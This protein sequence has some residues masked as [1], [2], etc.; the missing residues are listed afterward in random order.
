MSTTSVSRLVTL[1]EQHLGV[2]LLR[3]TTRH[4]HVTDD[5]QRYYGKCVQILKLSEEAEH[6][7]SQGE[8]VKGILRLSFPHDF[9]PEFILPHIISFRENNPGV[10][11]DLIVTDATINLAREGVDIAIRI[12]DNIHQ[13]LIARRLTETPIICC[14]APEYL[15]LAGHPTHPLDLQDHNCLTYALAGFGAL[16]P[17]GKDGQEYASQVSGDFRGDSGRVLREI[18]LKGLGIVLLPEFLVHRDI[19]EGRLVPVLGD[20][21]HNAFGIYAVYETTSRESQKIKSFLRYLVDVFNQNPQPW[22]C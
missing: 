8:E 11:F 21:S 19:A 10:T 1:L 17:F 6:E 18:A 13:N 16:W 3:R 7:I 20:Y 15:R 2:P 9:G 14:A 4:L 22:R 12:S 5:G